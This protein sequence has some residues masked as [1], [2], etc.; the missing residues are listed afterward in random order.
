VRASSWILWSELTRS[1]AVGRLE[2]GKAWRMFWGS[3]P[4]IRKKG[5]AF[6]ALCLWEL[7]TNSARGRWFA[8]SVGVVLQ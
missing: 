1:S 6:R 5:E 4:I 2:L 7:W 3:Y 8:H